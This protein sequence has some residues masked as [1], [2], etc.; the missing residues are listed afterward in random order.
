M[1]EGRMAEDDTEGRSFC[2]VPLAANPHKMRVRGKGNCT[3]GP[4][5]CANLC[6]N[7]CVTLRYSV[8]V[9]LNSN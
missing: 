2:V 1:I 5:L 7:L 4:S 8:L 3:K 6:V 9:F